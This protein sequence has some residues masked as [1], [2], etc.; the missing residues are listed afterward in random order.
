MKARSED[1][2]FFLG[3]ETLIATDRPG[4]AIWREHLFS[5]MSRNAQR[6]TAFFNIPADQVIE[7]GIQ[8]E[9]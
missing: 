5:F 6:A 7:V 8:V 3:R 9:L 2:T 1:L 4:M